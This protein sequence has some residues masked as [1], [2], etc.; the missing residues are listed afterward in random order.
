MSGFQ[1]KNNIGWIL[2]EIML[3]PEINQNTTLKWCQVSNI[4]S[5]MVGFWLDFGCLTSQHDFNHGTTLKSGCVPS[6]IILTPGR[7]V[8]F[9]GPSFIVSTMQEETTPIFKRFGMTGPSSNRESNPQILLVSA[10]SPL[11]SPF[12]ISRG[13]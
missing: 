3:Q 4:K 7:P 12:T 11:S 5:T 10:G 9:C 8:M 2:V 13:Y 1:P 6:G